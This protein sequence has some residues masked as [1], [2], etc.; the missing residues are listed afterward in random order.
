MPPKEEGILYYHL[1]ESDRK[2]RKVEFSC[3]IKGVRQENIENTGKTFEL[4]Q[5]KIYRWLNSR[6]DPSIPSYEDAGVEDTFNVLKGKIN[7]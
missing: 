5:T 2:N 6:A 7:S 3:T 1:F 4:Y